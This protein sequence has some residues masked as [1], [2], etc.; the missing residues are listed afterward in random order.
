MWNVKRR[1]LSFSLRFPLVKNYRCAKNKISFKE[2][3]T[4]RRKPNQTKW[5]QCFL[6]VQTDDLVAGGGEGGEGGGGAPP[7]RDEGVEPLHAPL[8]QVQEQDGELPVGESL[9][10]SLSR[11]LEYS[12]WIRIRMNAYALSAFA[13]DKKHNRHQLIVSL[14]SV[15]NIRRV[16]GTPR[17]PQLWLLRILIRESILNLIWIRNT[18]FKG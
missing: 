16:P 7:Q 2:S 8:P 4:R 15:Y 13:M 9:R 10:L 14:Y 11:L 18:F 17:D 1:P 6:H 3:K 5:R 12:F